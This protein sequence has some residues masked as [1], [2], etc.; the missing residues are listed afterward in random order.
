MV[1]DFNS[2]E[3]KRDTTKYLVEFDGSYRRGGSSLGKGEAA[4]E[5]VR[6]LVESESIQDLQ[7]LRAA[8]PIDCND[9]YK[10]GRYFQH[11][12]YEYAATYEYDG[13][14]ASGIVTGNWDFYRD[15]KHCLDLNGQKVV[16]LKM[17]RKSTIEG[18]IKYLEKNH[19]A[20]WKRLKIVEA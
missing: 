16:M 19:N 14:E 7:A 8:L 4:L 9:Y 1:I 13:K 3:E 12:F 18:L 10:T 6:C 15:D 17:W 2:I 11:L 5:I 20:F